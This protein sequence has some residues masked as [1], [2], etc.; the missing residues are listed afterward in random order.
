[1]Q[2]PL[3]AWRNEPIDRQHLQHAIKARA[4]AIGRQSLGPEAFEL[5]LAPDTPESQHAPNWRGRRSRISLSRNR[6]TSSPAGVSQRYWGDSQSDRREHFDPRR[7]PRLPRAR[8]SR[9]RGIDHGG[10]QLMSLHH[11]TVVEPPGQDERSSRDDGFPFFRRSVFRKNMARR[12][13]HAKASL[14]IPCEF[15]WSSLQPFLA[16]FPTR[17]SNNSNT[18]RPRKPGK[19]HVIHMQIRE[20]GLAAYEAFAR[21]ASAEMRFTF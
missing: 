3:A 8:A 21:Q 2:S 14:G 16:M 18:Y 19:D 5:Q 7:T 6:K 9:R 1:M 17:A 10:I 15:S 11:T 20:V 4:L 12:F 13:C